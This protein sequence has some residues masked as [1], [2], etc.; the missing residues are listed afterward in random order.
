MFKYS[1]VEIPDN[2]RSIL[3]SR[4]HNAETTTNEDI[5]NRTFMPKKR[6]WFAVKEQMTPGGGKFVYIYNYL[7]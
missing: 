2:C 7:P 5:L 3:A 4:N 6:H 1:L